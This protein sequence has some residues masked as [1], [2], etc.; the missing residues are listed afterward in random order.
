M[1][2]CQQVERDIMMWRIASG[3]AVECDVVCIE[4]DVVLSALLCYIALCYATLYITA[5][6]LSY[7][8]F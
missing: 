3:S 1:M 8:V 2:P 7:V 6:F 4:R 5:L